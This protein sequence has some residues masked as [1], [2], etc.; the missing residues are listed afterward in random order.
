MTWKGFT[1]DG[2]FYDLTHLQT[3]LLDVEVDGDSVKLHV[4]Y[5]NHCFTDKKENGPMLFKGERRY[6][7]HERYERSKELP[8]LIKAKLL[9]HYAIPYMTKS[10]ESYHYM[11]TFDYAIFF[12][13]S[14][15]TGTTNELNM[16]INSAYE[17]DEWGKGSLP[18][19]K[20]KRVSWILSQRLKG[21]SVLKRKRK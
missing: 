14:K 21:Q 12:S 7:C 11:E 4:S 13:L 9:D 8:G 16:R 17:L 15:P 3:S 18:K 2:D 20:P 5:A 19:G 10:G 6:W 1:I